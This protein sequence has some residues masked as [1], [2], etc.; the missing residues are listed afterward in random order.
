[1]KGIVLAGGKGTRLYPVTTAIC[2][3]LLPVYD[4]PM[5]YYPLSVLM[6]AGIQEVMIIS[7]PEDL[8]RFQQMLG[9]GDRFGL[10]LSFK[11]QP[12]P[13]GI[14]Q[15]FLIAESFIG[16][17]S[18]GLILGDNIF[19]GRDLEK[20]LLSSAQL[21]EGGMVFAYQVPDPSRYG[22]ITFDPQGRALTIVEKPEK[23]A[24]SYALTGLYF[25]DPQVIEIAK[26][27]K[28]SL[29]GELEITDVNNAYLKRG[30]LQVQTL[31]SD[32]FWFDTGTHDALHHASSF[33]QNIQG[34]QGSKVGCLEEIAYRKGFIGA[35][36]LLDA[37]S[38]NKTSEYSQYL[39]GVYE[40]SF[41]GK[42]V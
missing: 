29:R 13:D 37:A 4:K 40:K 15:A 30:L 31:G 18:V 6:Q 24:S 25:Y 38:Q 22:V 1:M 11:A 41:N 23:P 27:L 42:P 10:S 35:S 26:S 7:T 28:P 16:T 5:I 2:K 17:D 14:A 39:L 8:P 36:Q 32:F 34:K 33:V 19:Y 20:Q 21:A 9:N 3:Q 12:S